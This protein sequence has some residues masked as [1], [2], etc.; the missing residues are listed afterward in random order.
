MSL[1][2]MFDML[3]RINHTPSFSKL[4][5]KVIHHEKIN[6]VITKDNGKKKKL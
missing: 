1:R 4:D 6:A 3:N 2:K 5:A